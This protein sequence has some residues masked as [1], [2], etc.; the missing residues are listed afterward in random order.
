MAGLAHGLCAP[1]FYSWPAKGPLLDLK[2]HAGQRRSHLNTPHDPTPPCPS[3]PT[4][5][6]SPRAPPR[7]ALRPLSSR[8]A[9]PVPLP[10]GPPCAMS[11]FRAAAAA[12]TRQRWALRGGTALACTVFSSNP[13]LSCPHVAA[14]CH[15]E[16]APTLRRSQ[17]E[18]S[19]C[20]LCLL[21]AW[22]QLRICWKLG[23]ARRPAPQA[24]LSRKV[25]PLLHPLQAAHQEE[26]PP[27]QASGKPACNLPPLPVAHAFSYVLRGA[28]SELSAAK[29]TFCAPSGP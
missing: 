8:P 26:S 12:R 21:C 20:L 3:H 23:G 5:L 29:V 17:L 4:P 11:S 14:G 22:H 13:A 19:P 16:C 28:A 10:P 1:V 24:G 25:L 15:F 7:R 18:G 27:R 2:G 6:C 9:A